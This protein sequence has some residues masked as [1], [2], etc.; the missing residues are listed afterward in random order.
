MKDKCVTV[1]KLII[2][3]AIIGA[4]LDIYFSLFKHIDTADS[5]WYKSFIVRYKK[6]IT[7]A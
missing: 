2:M 1:T 4:T 3:F 5:F 7:D 6:L